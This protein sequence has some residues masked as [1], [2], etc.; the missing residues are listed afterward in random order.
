MFSG[1]VINWYDYWDFSEKNTSR[2][3]TQ[4]L[5]EYCIRRRFGL[6]QFFE[7]TCMDATHL[8]TGIKIVQTN[9]AKAQE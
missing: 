2:G 3:F 5:N 1:Q 9:V 4:I 6:C 8:Q 7:H